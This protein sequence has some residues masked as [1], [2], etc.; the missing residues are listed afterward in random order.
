[1]MGT[2]L[3]SLLPW[4]TRVILALQSRSNPVLDMFFIGVTLLGTEGVYLLLLPVL[5]W[6][7]NKKLGWWVA[8]LV[9]S[10][11]YLNEVLKALFQLPRP[12]PE[13]VRRVVSADGWGFPSGHA[14]TT[15]ALFGY[16]ALWLWPR[17]WAISLWL[18]PLLVSL[19]RL[20]L[21]VHYP[22][23]VLGGI[24]IG[25]I[26]LAF[27][28]WAVEGPPAKWWVCLR[29]WEQTGALAL[30]T[31]GL[32]APSLSSHTVA[33]MGA[34]LGVGCGALWEREAVRFTPQVSLERQVL[35]LAVGLAILLLTYGLGKVL[36]PE[37]PIYRFLRYAVLGGTATGVLPWLFLRWGWGGPSSESERGHTS[38]ATP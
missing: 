4:G 12:N 23:D 11:T 18:V 8:L 20:Y 6:C 22:H 34:L 25:L 32:A 3:T 19:S 21:G 2:F 9:L 31:I 5:M 14:Q 7:L 35:K 29:G 28:K 26:L 13:V 27:F 15:T 17:R 24:L 30:I 1:M 16:L 10:S 36:L 38:C 37:A 33:I